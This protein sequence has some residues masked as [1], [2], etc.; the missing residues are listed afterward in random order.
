MECDGFAGLI[1]RLVPRLT[2]AP[3]VTPEQYRAIACNR[4]GLCC[5]DIPSPRAPDEVA[6]LLRS[7]RLDPDRREF[8]SGLIPVEPL[9]SGW[10]YRCRHFRR[11]EDGT[12]VCTIHDRRPEVCRRF[13]YGRVV[14]R[15]TRCA[16][17]V[18]VRGPAGERI[19]VVDE[20]D[21]LDDEPR[22]ASERPLEA[23]EN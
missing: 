2:P 18:Q 3:V 15:W 19:D 16:W 10:R 5:E 6:A 11:V 17:Y 22:T 1:D 20:M 4:C 12:G 23:A 13:P 8:L 14:R 7:G 21:G 9:A